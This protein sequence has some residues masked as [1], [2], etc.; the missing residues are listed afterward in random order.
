MDNMNKAAAAGEWEYCSYL[1]ADELG[2][3]LHLFLR[4]GFQMMD[5]VREVDDEPVLYEVTVSWRRASKSAARRFRRITSR[6]HFGK[7]AG[8]QGQLDADA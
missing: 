7:L 1:C 3:I 6:F 2:D 5:C 4:M 8:P